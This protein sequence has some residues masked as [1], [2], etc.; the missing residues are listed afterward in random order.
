MDWSNLELVVFAKST[1]TAKGLACLPSDN[2]LAEVSLT[3]FGDT[4]R[5]ADDP[6]KGKVTWKV[7]GKC[8]CD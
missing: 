6:F 8:E 1:A 2:H 7:T 4:F 5:L 3:R